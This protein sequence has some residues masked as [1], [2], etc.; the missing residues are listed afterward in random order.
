MKFITA[1]QERQFLFLAIA[2]LITLS[3]AG[4][5]GGCDND[6]ICDWLENANSC[7]DCAVCGN[8]D[9]EF[10]EECDPELADS[11][12]D[13]GFVCNAHCRCEPEI[14]IAQTKETTPL[15]EGPGPNY[16]SIAE[17]SPETTAEVIGISEDGN[18]WKVS[19]PDIG[20]GWLRVASVNISGDTSDIPIAAAPPPPE[21]ATE[22]IGPEERP[23]CCYVKGPT[24]I[25][26]AVCTCPCPPEQPNPNPCTK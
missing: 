6:G 18:Y 5:G 10:G 4:C 3:L 13:D 8:G 21:K 26:L 12:C 9:L 16:P 24:A 20:E 2:I 17:L 19:V 11:P 14:P 1:I 15:R 7:G 22:S 23:E 25:G